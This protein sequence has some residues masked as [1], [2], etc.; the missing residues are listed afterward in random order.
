[1]T[2]QDSSPLKQQPLQLLSLTVPS[3]TESG[4]SSERRNRLSSLEIGNAIASNLQYFSLTLFY[5][6]YSKKEQNDV[7]IGPKGGRRE[8]LL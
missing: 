4:A 3:D 6:S 2:S 7:K 8:R 5:I 1:M